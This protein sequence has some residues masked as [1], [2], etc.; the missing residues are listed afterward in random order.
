MVFYQRRCVTQVG[1][2]VA[3]ILEVSFLTQFR[4]FNYIIFKSTSKSK[5]LT[6]ADFILES[7]VYYEVEG[8]RT[9]HRVGACKYVYVYGKQK[10]NL[11]H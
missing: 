10:D 11:V 6:F 8:M 5:I 1:R 2:K 9:R 3:A 7:S 4:R